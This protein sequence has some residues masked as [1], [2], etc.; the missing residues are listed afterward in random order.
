MLTFFLT[1]IVSIGILVH[2]K[3]QK[4][5]NDIYI[6][7][8]L[9]I[10]DNFRKYCILSTSMINIG[11]MHKLF[12]LYTY[13]VVMPLKGNLISNSKNT[14]C[15]KNAAQMT[16]SNTATLSNSNITIAAFQYNYLGQKSMYAHFCWI[17]WQISML[18]SKHSV[19]WRPSYV[20]S[21]REVIYDIIT[22]F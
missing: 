17:N 16:L 9:S 10:Y 3:S 14:F 15:D 6:L 13:L 20:I 12:F 18:W 8:L 2:R 7:K 19:W 11:R 5:L 4:C 1:H 22:G 21:D